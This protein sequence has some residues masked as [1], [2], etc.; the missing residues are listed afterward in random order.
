[1]ISERFRFLRPHSG[2]IRGTLFH[3]GV[4]LLFLLQ[5]CVEFIFAHTVQIGF[6][7]QRRHPVSVPLAAFSIEVFLVW[8][9]TGPA[10]FAQA[11][12]S[13]GAFF[14]LKDAKMK[15]VAVSAG[16][17]ALCG[18]T[19]PALYGISVKYK[20]PMIAAVIAGTIGG[21]ICGIGGARAYAVAIP[22]LLTIPAFIGPGFAA[23]I[24]GIAAAFAVSF[25]LT[26]V[27]GLQEEE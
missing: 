19:E 4:F 20:K 2:L 13:F 12:A 27:L 10:N 21:A 17:S 11:G 7:L 14:R 8:A 22:S 3:T 23:F 18:I 24:V 15:S 25:A 5:V 16:I 6:I 1:M 26:L 9:F